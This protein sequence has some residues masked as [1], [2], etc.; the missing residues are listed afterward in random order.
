MA[1]K[2]TFAEKDKQELRPNEGNDFILARGDIT[3]KKWLVQFERH[4][5]GE[6][7]AN[8]TYPQIRVSLHVRMCRC[9]PSLSIVKRIAN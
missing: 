3:S 9:T 5:R 2:P 6:G 1:S 8:L 4:I 7:T